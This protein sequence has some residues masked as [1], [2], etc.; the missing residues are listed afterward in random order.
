M[1][2]LSLVICGSVQVILEERPVTACKYTRTLALLVYLAIEADRPHRRE[3]LVALLWPELPEPVARTNL[4]QI[5]ADLRKAL[6]GATAAH[7]FLHVT[8]ETIQ[9]NRASD[10]NLD[11]RTFH[12]LLDSCDTH[13]HRSLTT[14]TSCVQRLQQAV[15]LYH[16]DVLTQFPLPDSATYEEWA[17]LLREQAHQRMLTALAAL[18]DYHMQR[19][20][21]ALAQAAA[22]RQITLDPW[23]EEAYRQ[24]MQALAFSGE[25]SAALVQYATC[26]RVLS[27]A[28]GVEPE[29]E[30]TALYERVRSGLLRHPMST[31]HG[32]LP[33]ARRAWL[34]TP[35]TT[36]I[37]RADEQAVITRWLTQGSCRLLTL[38]GPPGVGKTRLGLQAAADL[39]GAFADGIYFVDLAPIH[40]PDLVVSAIA[41][42]IGIT[43][44]GDQPLLKSLQVSLRDQQALLLLDNFEQILAAGPSIAEL[45]TACPSLRALVTSRATLSVR[46]EHMLPVSPLGL[47]NHANQADVATLIHVPA[48][49][50]F[51]ERLQ[52]VRPSFVVSPADAAII[53][54]ICIRL[55]GLPLAI[56]LAAARGSLYDPAA[57][58]AHLDHRLTLLTEGTRDLPP[59]Q[60]TLRATID[61]SYDLLETAEQAL[62]ALLGVFVGGCTHEAV[63]A[64]CAATDAVH[65]DSLKGLATLCDQSLL[66]RTTSGDGAARFVM[67]ETLR[68]YALEELERRGQTTAVR[69]WHAAYYL[70]LAELAETHIRES[71]QQRW[72][73]RLESEHDNLRAALVWSLTLEGDIRLG[74]RI[75]VALRRFWQVRGHMAEGRKHLETFLAQ[76]DLSTAAR[77]D[78]LCEL[79]YLALWQGDNTITPAC[80][81]ESLALYRRVGDQRGTA[82][83]LCGLGYAAVAHGDDVSARAYFL[84]SQTLFRALGKLARV[85]W[86]YYGLG[87]IAETQGDLTAARAGY[88]QGLTVFGEVGDTHGSGWMLINLGVVALYQADDEGAR[89]RFIESQTLF[90]M[91]NDRRGLA[92]ALGSLAALARLQGDTVQ[93]KELYAESLARFRD[94]GD[95]RHSALMLEALSELTYWQGDQARAAVYAA[96]SHALFCDLPQPAQA[97]EG[98]VKQAVLPSGDGD[99]ASASAETAS[100]LVRSTVVHRVRKLTDG[101]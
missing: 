80:W 87:R 67:L 97:A 56:E 71:E 94:L 89:E 75:A 47:P 52:A 66:W 65:Q 100:D 79:G 4:R 48:V 34:P 14:C 17:A 38:V 22:R 29:A 84:E 81:I 90:Q 10:H 2:H 54:A 99:L 61:W 30:T 39:A 51:V 63:E 27:E 44:A 70:A 98:S 86:T 76:P 55:N 83:S 93:A 73:E 40:D 57:I 35:L 20:E 9:F 74:I 69:A 85:A 58:L 59:R 36:C 43:E 23:R 78:V 21:Y 50:L 42:A 68:E 49:A 96:Q 8:R 82:E 18:I 88:E 5:L 15:G 7:T 72:H 62:F 6:G 101:V 41:Q 95:Q 32:A 1:A 16:G 91:V 31:A 46:G 19:G 92:T 33:I 77:A 13:S 37:G 28:L 25:R 12:T 60:Q 3:A 26:R 45:L 53:A 11:L 24:L 64:A